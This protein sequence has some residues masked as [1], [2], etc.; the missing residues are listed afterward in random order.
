M[1]MDMEKSRNYKELP[2]RYAKL[3]VGATVTYVLFLLDTLD[4]NKK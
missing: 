4:Y 2:E 1:A 3:A